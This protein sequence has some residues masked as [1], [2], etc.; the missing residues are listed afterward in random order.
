[1]TRERK[2]Q[3]GPDSVNG[4]LSVIVGVEIGGRLR[5]GKMG[6]GTREGIQGWSMLF[7]GRPQEQK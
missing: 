1:V 7:S 3:R 5:A 6:K 2:K 4:V